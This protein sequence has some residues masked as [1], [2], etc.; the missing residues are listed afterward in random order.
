MEHQM[1]KFF[2]SSSKTIMH[3][4][5]VL[6]SAE[7]ELQY[8]VSI[9]PDGSVWDPLEGT[10]FDSIREWALFVISEE[11]DQQMSFSKIAGKN[12]YDDE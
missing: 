10:W 12:K 6:S 5:N 11:D 4:I 1:S 7:L 8:G 9:D 3:D 2:N